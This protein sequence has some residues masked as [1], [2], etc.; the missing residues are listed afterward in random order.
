MMAPYGSRVQ[1]QVDGVMVIG[2][3]IW[4]DVLQIGEP[5]QD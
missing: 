1:T 3:A 2:E 4:R 5:K